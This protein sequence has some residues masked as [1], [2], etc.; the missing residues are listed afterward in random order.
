MFQFQK[1]VKNQRFSNLSNRKYYLRLYFTELIL[2][3]TPKSS[4][5]T[6]STTFGHVFR[7]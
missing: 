5:F 1:D 6:I 3:L 7:T 4:Q 2:L